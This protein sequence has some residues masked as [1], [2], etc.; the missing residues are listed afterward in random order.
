MTNGMLMMEFDSKLKPWLTKE[1]RR[2]LAR[3]TERYFSSN[4][5]GNCY[6]KMVYYMGEYPD[7]PE[8][9]KDFLL[10]YID[11]LADDDDIE[12]MAHAMATEW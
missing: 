8:G 6:E 1:T 3:M 5:Q 9:L 2:K 4:R 7:D 10:E 11:E 12:G